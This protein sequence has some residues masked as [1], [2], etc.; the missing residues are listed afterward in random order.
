M[1]SHN[2]QGFGSRIILPISGAII[3]F[4]GKIYVDNT[5]SIIT[6]PEFKTLLDMLEGIR[7]AA[8][9]W[10]S[11][12]NATSGAI[13]LKKRCWIHEGYTWKNDIWGYAT[14]PDLPMEIPLPDC[15][16]PQSVTGR[17]QQ[18]RRH[19]GCGPLWMGMTTS[20]WPKMSMSESGSGL[21]R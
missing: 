19:W 16:W 21:P 1:H 6:C 15:S 13:N 4:L 10:A 8:W 17:S 2:W 14:Q 12:L 20:T 3:D 9:A 5:D 7:T 11:S 18:Q